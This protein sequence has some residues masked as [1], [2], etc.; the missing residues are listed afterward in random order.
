MNY[1]EN[2]AVNVRNLRLKNK[3]NYAELSRR[4][5][6]VGHD[7]AVLALRRIEASERKVDVNDLVAFSQV[8]D[9]DAQDLLLDPAGQNI[10]RGLRNVP[11]NEQ[12]VVGSGCI[13][14]RFAL[15]SSGW[16]YQPADPE[17]T[18]DPAIWIAVPENELDTETILQS[19][20]EQ[21]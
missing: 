9:V 20:Q 5:K 18:R 4:L 12:A 16:I 2:V 1:M 21:S 11:P 19:T 10:W 13:F 6:E 17:R 8:F 3:L 15:T 7:L 14:A